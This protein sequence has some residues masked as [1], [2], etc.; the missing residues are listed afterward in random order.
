[1]YIIIWFI[2]FLLVFKQDI[3]KHKTSMENLM[4]K[5]LDTRLKECQIALE[6]LDNSGNLD[7]LKAQCKKYL[8]VKVKV[9][10]CNPT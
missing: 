1:M 5:T 8:K 6:Y 9:Y 2:V 4:I 7:I 10:T 3:R